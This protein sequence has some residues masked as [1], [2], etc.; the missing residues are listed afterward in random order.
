MSA[1]T[2]RSRTLGAALAL[3][4]LLALLVQG[5]FLSMVMLSASRPIRP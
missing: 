3:L 1:A 5:L 2:W 4:A